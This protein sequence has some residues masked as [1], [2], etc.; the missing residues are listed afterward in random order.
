M[1]RKDGRGL[2]DPTAGC[3]ASST[4]ERLAVVR[5]SFDV[6]KFFIISRLENC[7]SM[8]SIAKR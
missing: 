8:Q 6:G 7:L 3:F 5:G 1:G 4:D 2:Q